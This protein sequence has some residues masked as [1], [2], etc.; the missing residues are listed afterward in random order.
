MRHGVAIPRFSKTLVNAAAR[1]FPTGMRIAA[2]LVVVLALF[3]PKTAGAFCG[4]YVSGVDKTL[5]NKATM[6]V[7]MRE[8]TRTVLSMQNNYEGPPSDFAMV[9]PVP[10]VLQQDNVRTLSRDVFDHVDQL[11]SPRLVEYWE[12]DPCN[13]QE[14]LVAGLAGARGMGMAPM[15][16]TASAQSDL[17][18]TVEAKFEVGEYQ[19]LI[20]SAENAAG[21]DA[22]LRKEGYRIP[23]GAEPV[24]RPYVASGTKFF[25]AKVDPKKLT[26]D[27]NGRAELS[28]LRF[29]Y[30]DPKF[31]LPI[32]LGLINSGGV[33]DLIVHILAKDQRYE[34]ANYPNVTIPTNIDVD[35]AARDKF[36]SFYVKLL[37]ATIERSPRAIVT[38]YAWSAQNCDPCPGPVLNAQDL[39]TLGGDV[40]SKTE[41]TPIV[42][43]ATT[44]VDPPDAPGDAP[45]QSLVY[46]KHAGL[47]T[48]YDAAL[49]GKKGLTGEVKLHFAVDKTGAVKDLATTGSELADPA[50][51]ACIGKVFSTGSF[52]ARKG[53]ATVDLRVSLVLAPAAPP[54]GM[55]LTRLHAR[56]GKDSMG[57]DLVFTKA[58]PIVGGRET[59]TQNGEL[60]RGAQKSSFN[61]FQARY[62]IRHPW[63]GPIAC[64]NP[65]RGVWGA[66]PAGEATKGPETR[67]ARDLAFAPREGIQLASF[68]KNDPWTGVGGELAALVA[69]PDTLE[70][71]HAP[72]PAPSGNAGGCMGCR[73]ADGGSS[74]LATLS[75]ALGFFG[76]VALRL[77]RRRSVAQTGTHADG[78]LRAL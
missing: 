67:A 61:N 72:I 51:I 74:G 19:I 77:R 34:V 54:M 47:R 26:F 7:L 66:P 37:D 39:I 56:Y 2:L 25:V 42:R 60:E 63:K 31:E 41:G 4:F 62:A 10:V 68:V 1:V 17:G 20:L 43:I 24:L 11:A 29:H 28:P 71:R 35:E 15:A 45:F 22:W 21:L 3:I 55:V 18:V 30:D 78:D 70:K 48:C 69:G 23:D 12:Q 16:K 64:D 53:R 57:E 46:A 9:V 13:R 27:A 38:E 5:L 36:S 58:E 33:Q 76:C 44:K 65:R 52:P 75:F 49:T 6:V 8:G 40:L 59:L 14:G 32:R 73:A 50:A